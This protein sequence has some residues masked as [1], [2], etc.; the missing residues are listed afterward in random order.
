MPLI[1]PSSRSPGYLVLKYTA[2]GRLHRASFRLVEGVDLDNI[3][4]L[5]TQAEEW[6]YAF[7]Q[8]AASTHEATGWELHSPERI[9][10]Y[11]EAFATAYTGVHSEA[12]GVNERWQSSTLTFTGRGVGDSVTTKVGN[13]LTR[14]FVGATYQFIKGQKFL[15]KDSDAGLTAMYDFLD[16]CII[17]PADFYGQHVEMRHEIAT[18]WNSFAENHWG[19]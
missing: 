1:E 16:G 13:A 18:D 3:D 4:M 9:R 12:L 7:S 19:A 10:L 11:Q 5:R 8:F 17:G 2:L 15:D 14:F 6:G